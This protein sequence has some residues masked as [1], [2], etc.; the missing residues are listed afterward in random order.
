MVY[1]QEQRRQRLSQQQLRVARGRQL[2]GEEFEAAASRCL[3]ATQVLQAAASQCLLEARESQALPLGLELRES[4]AEG[5]RPLSLGPGS[6]AEGFHL[7][8][9][10]SWEAEFQPPAPGQVSWAAECCAEERVS[11]VEEQLLALLE[12][13]LES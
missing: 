2:L 3:M 6:L 1:A 4:S 5:C 13:L 9:L 8:A 10:G 12:S 11:R 7:L